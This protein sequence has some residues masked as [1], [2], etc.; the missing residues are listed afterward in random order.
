MATIELIDSIV[1]NLDIGK[2]PN[3]IFLDLSKAVDTLDH[4]ILFKKLEHYGINPTP[5]SWFM[6][7]YL[8]DRFQFVS[9][10]GENSDIV[11]I[12]RGVPQGSILGPLL[13]LIYSTSMI[14][15][16]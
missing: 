15:I 11:P 16:W 6:S 1:H 9:F 3:S 12:S 8:T 10:L 13:F 5:L 2:L 14:F 7:S 4:N